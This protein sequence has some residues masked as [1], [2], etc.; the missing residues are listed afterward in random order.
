MAE[1]KAKPP[2]PTE[3]LST[4]RRPATAEE[5]TSPQEEFVATPP[6]EP[7]AE[8]PP[9][10]TPP[11]EPTEQ[12]FEI[13]ETPPEPPPEEL[14]DE[15]KR[16]QD[17]QREMHDAKQEIAAQRKMIDALVKQRQLDSITPPAVAADQPPPGYL[18]TGMT[19]E[20]LSDPKGW[21]KFVHRQLDARDFVRERQDRERELRSFMQDNPKWNEVFPIME[22]IKNENPYAYQEPGSLR[23]LHKQALK[24]QKYRNME[25][26]LREIESRALQTG[27]QTQQTKTS[28]PFATPRAGGAAGVPQKKGV[29]PPD[30]PSWSTDKQLQWMKDNKM[31]KEDYF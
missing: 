3:I 4:T 20:E 28:R 19:P 24:E 31:Y 25:A 16:V 2:P 23:A 30:F 26:K 14:S 17:A 22:E 27:A 29:M 15:E 9:E 21:E 8:T 13:D 5:L 11:Q 1:P 10:E 7:P 18:E 12:P 6:V